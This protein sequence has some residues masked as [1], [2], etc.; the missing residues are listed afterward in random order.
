VA[1]AFAVRAAAGRGGGPRP[2]DAPPPDDVAPTPQEGTAPQAEP[3]RPVEAVDDVDPAATTEPDGLEIAAA[4]VPG[5]ED[6]PASVEASAPDAAPDGNGWAPSAA[7]G[8]NGDHSPGG[9]VQ[10]PGITADGDGTAPAVGAGLLAAAVPVPQAPPEPE[11]AVVPAP[12]PDNDRVAQ[13]EGPA[14][15]A[16]DRLLAVLLD[17]PERAVGAV[18]ELEACLREL[19]RLSD[20]VRAGRAGLRDVLHRLAV[21][22]L[23]PDQLARLARLPQAE[24][25]ELLEAAPAEQH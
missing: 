7:Y 2:V 11:P 5:A 9:D 18:V 22:G 19:D 3:D 8:S 10:Q 21:A 12:R 6:E 17:D 14:A 16:R 25:Q 24:V 1:Q 15:D 23:R 4:A 20:A 13:Q